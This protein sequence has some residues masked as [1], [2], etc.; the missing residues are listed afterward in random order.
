MF[1]HKMYCRHD[2]LCNITQKLL[3]LHIKYYFREY[4]KG[5]I[6]YNKFDRFV[7]NI[8][9]NNRENLCYYHRT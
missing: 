1:S 5:H 4:Y 9:H 8:I 7:D 3:A 2:P 6:N